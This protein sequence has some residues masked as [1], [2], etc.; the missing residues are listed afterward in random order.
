MTA[1]SMHELFVALVAG[2]FAGVIII[3]ASNSQLRSSRA[4]ALQALQ[5]SMG[6]LHNICL[7]IIGAAPVVCMWLLGTLRTAPTT[8]DAITMAIMIGLA[9]LASLTLYGNAM[10]LLQERMSTIQSR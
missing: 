2:A 3:A 1:F 10:K 9:M 5:Q 8:L 7:F 6:P 4:G